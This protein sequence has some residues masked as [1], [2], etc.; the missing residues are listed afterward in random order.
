MG[1]NVLYGI[2]KLAIP[3]F[4]TALKKSP[5]HFSD[6]H[7]Q[8]IIHEAPKSRKGEIMYRQLNL[9]LTVI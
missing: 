6:K 7:I 8:E 4:E 1:L 5:F 9:L 2:G 3:K